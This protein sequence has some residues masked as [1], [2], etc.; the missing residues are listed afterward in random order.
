MLDA[1]LRLLSGERPEER[2]WTADISYWIAGRR[3]RGDAPSAWETEEGYLQLCRSLGIMPYYWYGQ[4]WLAEPEYDETIHL[5]VERR[6][7]VS[8][9]EW[10]TPAGTLREEHR[11]L[12]SSCSTGCTRFPV[13]T[14]RDLRAW[15]CLIEHRRLRPSAIDDYRER[16][17]LWRQYDGLPSIALPRSPLAAFFYEWA[18]VENAVYLLADE[19][20]LVE[21][22]FQLMDEQEAP[23]LD[24]VRRL[25]PPLVH[26]AD[27]LS[28]ENMAGLYDRYLAPYSSA[29]AGRLARRRRPVRRAP[30][31]HGQGT[32][33][34]AGRHR[35]R[36]R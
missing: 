23:I 22:A 7:D 21:H 33:A 16:M 1:F 5:S 36:R 35:L 15:I 26:F 2:V 29:T 32:A 25:A 3:Y 8:V 11:F 6:G 18:G 31:W 27:N 12:P 4:F 17:I 20:E 30:G 34:Q 28:S 14:E 13:Q 10:I 24:A 9:R 19:P